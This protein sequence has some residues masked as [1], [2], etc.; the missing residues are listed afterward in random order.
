[1]EVFFF[2]LNDANLLYGVVC[3]INNIFLSFFLQLWS[4]L[5]IHGINSKWEMY[6]NF[7]L[8]QNSF[9]PHFKKFDN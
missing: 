3:T 4:K 1:M 2:L 9:L 7:K 6:C 5:K 8:P